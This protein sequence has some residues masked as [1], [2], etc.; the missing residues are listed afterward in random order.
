MIDILNECLDRILKGETVEQCLRNYPEQA[1]EL[2]P[3]CGRRWQPN[4]LHIQ[5]RAEFKAQA[6]YEFTVG[7]AGYGGQKDQPLGSSLSDVRSGWQ[8]GWGVALVV[9]I[10]VVVHRRR[11]NGGGSQ[12]QYAG[13]CSLF[14]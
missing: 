1:Q 6:R 5:P 12:Q 9:V 4:R 7:T 14:C 11:W 13:R 8:T 10:L 3:C 2:E